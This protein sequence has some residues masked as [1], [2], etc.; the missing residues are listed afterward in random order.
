MR[1]GSLAKY[2]DIRST[3]RTGDILAWSHTGNKSFYDFK[4]WLVKLFTKSKFTHVG[5]AWV[6]GSRVFILESVSAGVRIYP[7]SLALPCYLVSKG[8]LSSEQLTFAIS[9]AGQE[10]S[11][12]ECIKAYF[13]SN[14]LSNSSWQCAEYVCSVLN[15]P[16]RATPADVVKYLLD[17]GMHIEE[18]SI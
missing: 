15:L 11:T 18:L 17:R 6:V 14:N 13:N 9:K 7:L 4:L 2:S 12:I 5:I 3:I 8:H 10:Y 1:R 16:C